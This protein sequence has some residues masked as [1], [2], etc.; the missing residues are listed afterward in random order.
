[1][2]GYDPAPGRRAVGV[3]I[4]GGGFMAA[5]HAAASRRA[6]GRVVGVVASSAQ[7]SREAA[8]R[9]GA[10]RGYASVDEL[11]SDT[12]I[13]VVHVCTPNAQ[14]APQTLAALAAGKHVVTE[15]PLATSA[16]VAAHLARAAMPV[17]VVAAV[18]F[19][20]RYH[21]MVREARAR[22]GAG[23]LGRLLSLQGS[24][25]QDWLLDETDGNWRVDP[26]E[27]GSSRAFAD[28]GSHL[29]DLTE[30][31]TG[32]RVARLAAVTRTVHPERGG[33]AVETEDAAA[34]VVETTSGA[35]GT[36]QV[37]QTA[38]GRKNRL[39]L[40]LAGSA[41]SLGFDQEEPDTLWIGRRDA[42]LIVHRDPAT[43]R[44]DAARLSRV[45]AGHPMGYQDAF[46]S[47]VMDVHAAISGEHPD[48]L[49]LFADGVRAAILT[50]AVL[51]SSASRSWVDVPRDSPPEREEALDFAPPAPRRRR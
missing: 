7:R 5:V 43:L 19:V 9:I 34:L 42:S 24:Y 30:F 6:G 45:P 39:H 47:F 40:E 14:H 27:G 49:P 17:G 13:D 29:V 12:A 32:D 23:E 11:L 31:V 41:E 16:A 28:I 36:L 21:P 46:D 4:L 51:S 18:P 22:V 50:E 48:G 25:L 26:A 2:S 15:K 44:P 33:R 37:S 35:I 1:M 38:P 20:Y 3:G 8:E 10:E